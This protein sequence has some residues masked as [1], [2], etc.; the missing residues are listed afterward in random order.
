LDSGL[1]QRELA[2]QLKISRAYIAYLES[3]QRSPSATVIERYL[4]LIAN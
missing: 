4:K 2:K 3:G 1:S